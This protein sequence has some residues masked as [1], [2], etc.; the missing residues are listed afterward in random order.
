MHWQLP[1]AVFIAACIQRND[2]PLRA[3]A[4][5]PCVHPLRLFHRQRTDHHPCSTGIE[6]APH[7]VIAAHAA[8][9]LHLQA[10]IRCNRAQQWQQRV[11][12]GTGRIEINQMQPLRT[13]IGMGH[14]QIKGVGR[15]TRLEGV[16]ALGKTHHAAITHVN[17]GI[18]RETHAGC[19]SR[20]FLR[21]RAPSAAERSGWNCTPATVPRATA[22]ANPLPCVVSR[23]ASLLPTTA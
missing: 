15:I 22:A 18:D 16:V 3:K 7:V 14:G 10:A 8:T 1:D 9:G 13:G 11:A 20:K 21:K 12:S 6:H 4:A 5:Q 23:M 2:D 19:Q 17:G